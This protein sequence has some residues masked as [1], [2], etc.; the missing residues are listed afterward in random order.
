MNEIALEDP[1][2]LFRRLLREAE[3][4]E[5]KDANAAALATADATGAPSVRMVLV[6]DIEA[7]GVTFYTNIESRKGEELRANP[8]AALCVYWKSLGRQVRLEGPVSQVS[9]EEADA[10]FATRH[11]QSQIGAWASQQSR[12]LEGVLL[13]ERRAAEYALKFGLKP[14]PR[15]PFWTGFRLV[16]ARLEFWTEKPFR[17]HERLVFRRSAKGWQTERLFP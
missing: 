15:P 9:D 10:Y 13:L 12:P 4:S 14:V 2:D 11:R 5:P 17:L 3:G 16:P 7:R 1:I 8:R 6:K